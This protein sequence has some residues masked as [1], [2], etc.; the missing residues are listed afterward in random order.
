VKEGKYFDDRAATI[1]IYREVRPDGLANIRM[2]LIVASL[3]T[4]RADHLSCLGYRRPTTP[5]L[6]RLASEGALFTNVFANDIPTQPAHTS[7]FTG[8]FGINTGIVSHFFPPARLDS[9]MPWFPSMLKEAGYPTAA[10]DH[11]FV[12][13][14]WFSRGYQDYMVPP[15]RSRSPAETINSMAFPW[16]EEH[17][18]E[19]F[20]LFLHY[21]DAHI[22]YVPPDPFRNRYTDTSSGWRDPLLDRKIR[23]RPT[24]PLFKRNLY[25]FLDDI[26]NLDYIADLY[27]AE[28]AYLDF[29]LGQLRTKLE[30]LRILDE[31]MLVI[32]GDHGEI[33][34]EHDSWFDHAGLYDAVTHVPLIVWHPSS[35]P[36]TRVYSVTQ[37]VD[38]FPTLCDKMNLDIPN[39]TDGR[40]LLPLMAGEQEAYNDEVVLSECTWQAKRAIRTSEWKYIRCYD[41]GVY[42]RAGPELYRLTTDPDEQVNLATSRPEV[43]ASLDARLEAWINRQLQGRADPFLEVIREGLPAVVRLQNIIKEDAKSAATAHS[44]R[45]KSTYIADEQGP[46]FVR[47][48]ANPG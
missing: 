25:D 1:A 7:V 27:D 8:K 4:L 13:K 5:N 26:P 10:V 33:M 29:Q 46:R 14:D 36:A 30:D 18:L 12:M 6:D 21:W 32:F 23:E 3:D 48:P 42:D 17:A 37:L 34:T 31:T 24:Y 11:L 20:F 9:A 40:S 35:V 45:T 39:N 41:P 16:I 28:I 2:K 38:I 15:G 43:V 22:P 44:R 19:D 47:A